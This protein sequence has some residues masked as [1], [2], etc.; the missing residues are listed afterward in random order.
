M[1]AADAKDARRKVGVE[2]EEEWGSKPRLCDG[3]VQ[4]GLAAGAS[5]GKEVVLIDR[6]GRF[7]S[8]YVKRALP[9][10]NRNSPL[11]F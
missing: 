9:T 7:T 1:N 2:E 8:V 3:G 5:G 10:G 4:A 6:A 11:S